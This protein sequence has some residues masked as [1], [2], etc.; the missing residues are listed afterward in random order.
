MLHV[1]FTELRKHLAHFMNKATQDRDSILVTR[2]GAEPV[3]LLAQSEYES[4]LETMHLMSSPAN[5]KRL[6]EGIADAEA[7][8]GLEVVWDDKAQ[9]FKHL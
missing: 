7:G 4:M 1:S 8:K 2:Q 3:V 5:A 6:N 9:A